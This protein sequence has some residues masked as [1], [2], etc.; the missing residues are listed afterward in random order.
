MYRGDRWVRICLLFLISSHYFSFSEVAI[1]TLL[2]PESKPEL[3]R[4]ASLQGLADIFNHQ[5]E[6]FGHW[7]MK[8]TSVEQHQSFIDFILSTWLF[9][10]PTHRIQDTEEIDISSHTL[11][12]ASAKYSTVLTGDPEAEGEEKIIVDFIPLGYDIDMLE[13]RLHETY[14]VVDWFVIYESERTQSGWKKPLYFR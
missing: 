6:L 3:T 10:E 9:L 13:I 2:K 4:D 7:K 14:P 1:A 5:K 11:H 8:R 12:C